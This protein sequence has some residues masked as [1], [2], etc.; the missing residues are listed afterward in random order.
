M[1]GL[2]ELRASWLAKLVRAGDITPGKGL[3]AHRVD[4]VK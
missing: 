4:P 1:A 3:Y 2:Y